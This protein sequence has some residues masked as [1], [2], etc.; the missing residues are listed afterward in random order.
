V[1]FINAAEFQKDEGNRPAIDEIER[2]AEEYLTR[3]E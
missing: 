2:L 3:P 1:L